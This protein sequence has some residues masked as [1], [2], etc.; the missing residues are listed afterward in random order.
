MRPARASAL[1]VRMLPLPTCGAQYSHLV[2]RRH[3]LADEFFP[4]RRV[5]SIFTIP[6]VLTKSHIVVFK[7]PASSGHSFSAP[8]G[9]RHR[10]ISHLK[11]S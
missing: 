2:L 4:V 5:R 8:R 7:S 10:L 6:E 9:R 1:I 11:V 3:I